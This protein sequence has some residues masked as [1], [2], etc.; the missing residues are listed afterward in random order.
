MPTDPG[1]GAEATAAVLADEVLHVAVYR[2]LVTLQ[3]VATFEGEVA[4][5]TGERP[6][7]YQDRYNNDCVG[8]G[9]SSNQ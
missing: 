4:L 2:Q 8:V 7:L 6:H 1:A 5:V 3:A 9:A